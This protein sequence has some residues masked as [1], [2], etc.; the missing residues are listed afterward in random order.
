MIRYADGAS[1]TRSADIAI[2][3][4]VGLSVNGEAWLSFRCSPENLEA[5]AVGYL[6][7]EGFIQTKGEVA[8]VRVCEQGD[9][10][11][12]WLNQTVQK[13]ETW[14]R[15]S[16]CQ[17]GSTQSGQ[18]D[19]LALPEGLNYPVSVILAQIDYFLSELHK[20][21]YPQRG[22]HST[23]LFDNMEVKSVSNDI[24]RH[25]TLDKIAGDFLLRQFE[26]S[27]PVVITTGRISSEMVSKA[28]R[29]SIPLAISLHS[30]SDL[31]A[32]AAERAGLTLVGH[33]RRS[34]ID[35]YTHSE[36]ILT[37]H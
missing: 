6:Y 12:V 21:D 15:T 14:S 19:I 11:D 32:M 31:A 17:G 10:I 24:G 1:E 22:V 2:E 3:T 36:R 20:P 23:M 4:E 25:N 37:G 8:S 33:A 29:M 9:Q 5:L 26:L 16:G 27:E 34:Q 30:V 7:N 35:I 18:N 13:P 28:A